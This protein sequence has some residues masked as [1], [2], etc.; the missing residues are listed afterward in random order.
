MCTELCLV[1]DS[2]VP[3]G[4]SR[5]W[6]RGGGEQLPCAHW[7]APAQEEPLSFPLPVAHLLEVSIRVTSPGLPITMEMRL[8]PKMEHAQPDGLMVSPSNLDQ[9]FSLEGPY[10]LSSLSALGLLQPRPYLWGW[11]FLPH[12]IPTTATCPGQNCC[13]RRLGPVVLGQ[14]GPKVGG[15]EGSPGL[16]VWLH[17]FLSQASFVSKSAAQVPPLPSGLLLICS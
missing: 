2:G 12:T 10:P 17:P 15:R 5:D 16:E 3:Q 9:S 8:G 6:R 7:A 11:D 14:E 13:Q 4:P 1:C